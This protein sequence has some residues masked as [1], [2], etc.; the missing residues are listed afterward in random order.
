MTIETITSH[1]LK[2]I[3]HKGRHYK[4]ELE[5]TSDELDPY[6]LIIRCKTN[7][8]IMQQSQFANLTSV[9]YYLLGFY[10]LLD[11]LEGGRKYE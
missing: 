10:D 4:L 5:K 2:L 3:N 7:N 1:R 11:I 8:F 9:Y 6:N